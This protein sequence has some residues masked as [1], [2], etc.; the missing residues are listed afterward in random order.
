MVL[1]DPGLTLNSRTCKYVSQ[2][3]YCI[4]YII[5]LYQF[6]KS[7]RISLYL[8]WVLTYVSIFKNHANFFNIRITYKSLISVYQLS[9][10][11]SLST[12]SYYFQNV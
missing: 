9:K 5:S 7:P 10:S 1:V 2:V 6:S 8:S 11:S 4:V 12:S 3:Y